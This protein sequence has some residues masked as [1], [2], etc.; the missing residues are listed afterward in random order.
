MDPV[1]RT[2]L[3]FSLSLLCLAGCRREVP[4]PTALPPEQVASAMEQAF[5]TAQPE[6]KKMAVEFVSAFSNDT[7]RAFVIIQSLNARAGLT[8]EQK[9]VIARSMLAA[10]ERMQ[11]AAAQ[12]ETKAVEAV[13]TY[14][15]NK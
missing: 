11:A 8:P 2:A 14:R 10:N 5:K 9:Q 3:A 7:P 13:Q 15:S 4:P 1:K 6:L 12:G